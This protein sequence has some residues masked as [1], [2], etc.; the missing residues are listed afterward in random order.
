MVDYSKWNNI[1]DSSD[2]DGDEQAQDRTRAYQ[3]AMAKKN[4]ESG[5]TDT[6]G[7]AYYDGNDLHKIVQCKQRADALFDQGEHAVED[8]KRKQFFTDAIDCYHDILHMV[9]HKGFIFRCVGPFK[10]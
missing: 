8:G 9:R 3:E 4:Q 5:N 1:V 10:H 2:E 7:A 6:T